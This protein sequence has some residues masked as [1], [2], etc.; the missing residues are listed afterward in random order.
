M[1]KDDLPLL[2]F[3]FRPPPCQVIVFPLNARVG[4]HR[5]VAEKL[6]SRASQEQ[7]A[8]YWNLIAKKLTEEL[9]KRGLAPE[10]IRAEIL[11]F[12]DAVSAEMRKA[13]AI[14]KQSPRPTEWDDGP[15]RA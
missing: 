6:A 14:A 3:D 9:E 7:R 13:D 4:K 8:G 12:R 5:H 10:E 11:A 2:R 1:T 15:R